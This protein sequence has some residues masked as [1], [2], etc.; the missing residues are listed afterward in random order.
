MH[1]CAT[2]ELREGVARPLRLSPAHFMARSV[3]DRT[4]AGVRSDSACAVLQA[5][6]ETG[7]LSLWQVRSDAAD[8]PCEPPADSLILQELAGAMLVQ[9]AAAQQHPELAAT[10]LRVRSCL[11][12]GEVLGHS[13][14]TSQCI[15]AHK[16][17]GGC[18]RR[19]CE[20]CEHAHAVG[21]AV[22][23]PPGRQ[24]GLLGLCGCLARDHKGT[25]QPV[26]APA[27]RPP[28]TLRASASCSEAA[29]GCSAGVV[30]C[31]DL[32][33]ACQPTGWTL[34][35]ASDYAPC[36]CTGL[37]C[38]LIPSGALQ[39]GSATA[40]QLQQLDSVE[41]DLA[42]RSYNLSA[43]VRSVRCLASCRRLERSYLT[44][45]LT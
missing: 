9:L 24:R 20:R 34:P 39:A 35:R 44:A 5:M 4:A 37:H 22:C 19:L 8:E 31:P 40:K 27:A 10:K 11:L 26:A 32:P 29:A 1:P 2:V 41:A 45:G 28:Q 21:R 18:A 15:A 13:E 3:A 43:E 25:A 36:T 17:R 12:L 42:C 7:L 14:L 33:R 38:G 6:S 23:T 16:L 30:A